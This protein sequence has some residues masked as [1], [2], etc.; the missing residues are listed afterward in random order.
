M[1]A[2][3]SWNQIMEEEYDFDVRNQKIETL[4][5]ITVADIKDL[6]DTLLFKNPRRLNVKIYSQDAHVDADKRKESETLNSAFYNKYSVAQTETGSDIR[7]F[8]LAHDLLP[9]L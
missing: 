6:F 4:K 2:Q 3:R 8:Q 7:T 1:E 5:S 9:R